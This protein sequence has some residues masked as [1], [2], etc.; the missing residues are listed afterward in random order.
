MLAFFAGAAFVEPC[1]WKDCYGTLR[2]LSISKMFSL[3]LSGPNH[4]PKRIGVQILCRM[5]AAKSNMSSSAINVCWMNSEQS[6]LPRI[7]AQR[8]IIITFCFP[9]CHR[10]GYFKECGNDLTAGGIGFEAQG[11]HFN[12][13]G[14]GAPQD[15]PKTAHIELLKGRHQ[16]NPS[17]IS[18]LFY[19]VGFDQTPENDLF[20]TL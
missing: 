6:S 13:W 3:W 1:F 15:Y 16:P 5:A 12:K 10:A 2:N 4:H 9:S 8:F 11:R 20:P 19:R 7:L 14:Q 18:Q 17:E